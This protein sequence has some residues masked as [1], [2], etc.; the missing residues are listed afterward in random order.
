VLA[1]VAAALVAY[2]A[3]DDAR[4]GLGTPQL[5]ERAGRVDLP[6]VG[7]AEPSPDVRR[8]RTDTDAG[9]E[10][11]LVPAT[12]GSAPST[13]VDAPVAAPRS[14]SAP[15]RE[16]GTVA[17]S[18]TTEPATAAPTPVPTTT[19]PD[20]PPA[21]PPAATPQPTPSP[22]PPRRTSPTQ[23]AVVPDREEIEDPERIEEIIRD[24]LPPPAAEREPSPPPEVEEPAL[25]DPPVVP[26]PS[27][28]PDKPDPPAPP[29]ELRE[30]LPEPEP[31]APGDPGAE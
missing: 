24:L 23:R 14:G 4:F 30:L 3:V 25:P 28:E 29:E 18:P 2:A 6:A 10:V 22:S 16:G 13:A 1:V 15:V 31:D 9:V 5:D 8:R 27:A 20:T 19:P 26:E 11:A 7:T 21:E 17:P 12:G